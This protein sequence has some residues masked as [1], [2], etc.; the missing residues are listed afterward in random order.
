MDEKTIL[1]DL[2]KEKHQTSI[3]GQTICV[4]D[5]KEAEIICPSPTSK[6]QN[7]NRLI[8]KPSINGVTLEGNKTSE[9][10]GISG[11]DANFTYEQTESSDEWVI[12]H[13]LN[14][15][16][17]VSII[18]S[19]GDEVIGGVHYD[20]LNQVTITFAGAFKGTATL[21]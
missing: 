12:V 5:I 11:E 13:N 18:D 17:A 19:A 15:Y 20:S 3:Q 6:S 4:G 21:N 9:D 7:Y 16:P 8:N 10:L 2:G 1:Y 14:K